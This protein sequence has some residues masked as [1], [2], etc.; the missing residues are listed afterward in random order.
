MLDALVDLSESDPLVFLMVGIVAL[1]LLLAVLILVVLWPFGDD[2]Y[3]DDPMQHPFGD[4]PHLDR[5][6]R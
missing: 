2:I 1:A 6:S 3:I 5:R 4:M